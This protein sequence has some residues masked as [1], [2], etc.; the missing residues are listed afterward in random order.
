MHLPIHPSMSPC[1]GYSTYSPTLESRP[2]QQWKQEYRYQEKEAGHFSLLYPGDS[3][4]SPVV[5]L[6]CPAFSEACSTWTS[7]APRWLGLGGPRFQGCPLGQEA[8]AACREKAE[9]R[10]GAW[11]RMIG[12]LVVAQQQQQ[13][14]SWSN[15]GTVSWGEGVEVSVLRPIDRSWI[16]WGVWLSCRILLQVNGTGMYSTGR[17]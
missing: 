6:R 7:T 16:V 9:W 17:G 13:V 11:R 8:G 12:Q 1:Q 3:L 4:V 15:G 5:P 2:G 14:R 10:G